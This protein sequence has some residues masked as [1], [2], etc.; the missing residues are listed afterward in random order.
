MFKQGKEGVIFYS[1]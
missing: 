1:I